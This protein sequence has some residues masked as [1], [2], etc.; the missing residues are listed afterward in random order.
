MRNLS[1]YWTRR[2]SELLQNGE[3]G[4]RADYSQNGPASAPT[5]FGKPSRA[6]VRQTSTLNNSSLSLCF[7]V[8]GKGSQKVTLIPLFRKGQ[9][10][11]QA[12]SDAISH[13]AKLMECAS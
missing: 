10:S 12:V 4:P 9:V 2:V 11:A 1:G 3:Q 5:Q 13:A 6:S 7:V 8:S